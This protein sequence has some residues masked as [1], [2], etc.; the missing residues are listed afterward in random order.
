MKSESMFLI[1]LV[2]VALLASIPQ[3]PVDAQIWGA[4][5]VIVGVIAGVIVN[6]QDAVVRLLIYVL[7]VALPIFDN[8]LDA[9]WIV[10]PWFNTLL[11][12]VAIGFQGFAVGLFVMALKARIQGAQPIAS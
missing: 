3:I 12:N 10:G 9:V 5:L 8:S 2:I 4:V 6:Y 1:A 7:A 11:D